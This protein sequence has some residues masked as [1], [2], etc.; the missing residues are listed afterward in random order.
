M[1]MKNHGRDQGEA[2]S[3][4]GEGGGGCKLCLDGDIGR[5]RGFSRKFFLRGR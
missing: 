5:G 3:I 1:F 2:F 4:L